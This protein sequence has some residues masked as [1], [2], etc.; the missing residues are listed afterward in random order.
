MKMETDQEIPN[1]Q[2]NERMKIASMLMHF[3]IDL[4]EVAASGKLRTFPEVQDFVWNWTA[5]FPD[6]EISCI[7]C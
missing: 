3:S 7:A 5:A 2:F 6:E 1:N 4:F